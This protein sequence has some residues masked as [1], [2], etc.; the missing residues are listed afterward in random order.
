MGRPKGRFMDMV[1][2][3]MAEVQVTVDDTEDRTN[4]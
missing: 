3:N 1:K 2:E 4:N